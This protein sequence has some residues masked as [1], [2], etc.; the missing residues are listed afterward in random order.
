[1]D[2]WMDGC[3][4]LGKAGVE[5]HMEEWLANNAEAQKGKDLP[6]ITIVDNGSNSDVPELVDDPVWAKRVDEKAFPEQ[7]WEHFVRGRKAWQRK[8]VPG[9]PHGGRYRVYFHTPEGPLERVPAW[10]SYVL[11]GMQQKPTGAVNLLMLPWVLDI[12]LLLFKGIY[13]S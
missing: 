3:W 7:Y 11:P 8:Y 6:P 2:G 12:A 4:D 9:V 1:M 10:A 5:K 13:C